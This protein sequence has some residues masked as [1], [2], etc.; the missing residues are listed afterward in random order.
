[1]VKRANYC[2]LYL[3]NLK[4]GESF[5]SI[6]GRTFVSYAVIRP[7]VTGFTAYCDAETSCF[8]DRKQIGYKAK[9]KLEVVIANVYD[10]GIWRRT[11][12]YHP[13]CYDFVDQPC[14]RPFTGEPL[15]TQEDRDMLALIMKR[16][17]QEPA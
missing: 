12:F 13:E 17:N 11:E 6:E 10:D 5:G 3:M 16:R 4:N 8:D 2:K 15:R 14:D 9:R 1:M 7:I